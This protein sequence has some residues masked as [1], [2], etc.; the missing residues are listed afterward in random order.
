MPDVQWIK[1]TTTMF[2][3]DKIRLIEMM[4]EKDTL[5]VIWI[6]LLVQ[7]GRSNASGYICINE[8]IPYSD[9]MLSTLFNRPINSIRMAL[10]TFE[11]FGMIERSR[12]GVYISNWEKHQNMKGLEDIREKARLRVQKHREKQRLI[13]APAQDQKEKE[14]KRKTKDKDIDLDKDI[15]KESNVTRNVSRNVTLAEI[16]I[17]ETLQESD[18][19]EAWSNWQQHRKEIKKPLTFTS[20]KQQIQKLSQMGANRAIEAIKHSIMNGWQGIF[21]P[22]PQH[23][24]KAPEKSFLQELEEVDFSDVLGGTP[25]HE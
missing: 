8:N 10:E 17:P 18:F 22:K 1:I 20:A 4:P 12:K 19:K 14:A 21:E 23:N 6:K 5:L 25:N 11:R 3:D 9:E 15:D 24:R 16:E 2:D 13:E 7:A